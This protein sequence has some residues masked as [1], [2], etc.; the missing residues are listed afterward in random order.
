M[1]MGDYD[2]VRN[3]CLFINNINVLVHAK[4]VQRLVCKAPLRACKKMIPTQC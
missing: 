4:N 1:M 2:Y 3:L